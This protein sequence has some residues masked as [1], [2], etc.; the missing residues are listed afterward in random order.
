MV[1]PVYGQTRV[2]KEL[3]AQERATLLSRVQYDAGK[4]RE[5]LQLEA[6]GYD[7]KA[8]ETWHHIFLQGF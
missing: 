4:A 2:D 1:D 7:G 6:G 8:I 5:A 3:S